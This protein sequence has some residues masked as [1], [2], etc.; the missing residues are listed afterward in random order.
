[1]RGI[2]FPPMARESLMGLWFLCLPGPKPVRLN[3]D[4]AFGWRMSEFSINESLRVLER[5]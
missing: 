5:S 3:K 1:M 4:M 2:L